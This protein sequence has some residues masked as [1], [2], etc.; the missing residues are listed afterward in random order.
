MIT[1]LYIHIPFCTAKCNYCSFTS[2]VG[3]EHLLER[4]IDALFMEMRSLAS[5]TRVAPLET[6]FLG[7]GTPSLLSSRQLARLLEGTLA[8]FPA[9]EG[10]EIS[11][12]INPGTVERA[13]LLVF[14]AAGITR[15]S[16]GVQSFVDKELREIG[17]IHT[18]SEAQVALAMAAEIGFS[19][20]SL[21]LM[22]G[23]PGQ[24]PKSWRQ[25][26]EMAISLGVGHL[27][28]YHLTLE[29]KTPFQEMVAAGTLVLPPEEELEDM[30]TITTQLMTSSGLVQYE[31]SNYARDGQYC[32]HN[33]VYWENGQYLGVGA[34]AVSF[35][36]GERRRNVARPV[37]YC[38]R[39]EAG[40]PVV[41]ERETLPL[42]ASFRESVIMGLRLNRGV[43]VQVLRQRYGIHIEDYYGKTL[44]D[45]IGG[46]LVLLQGGRLMLS[47]RGRSF[48]NVVMA[49]LV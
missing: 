44:E 24:T 6:L 1:S 28:L 22:Y 40:E 31:I 11:I 34:A 5:S 15:L 49:D 30:D 26:L 21:D 17:R 47:K 18:A 38:E 13:K 45:L 8:I 4:Y 25:S 33:I 14:K 39:L 32:R 36:G 9:Q 3:L 27:S 29:D 20:I 37:S 2:Y 35:I 46:G 16:F 23:L 10:A 41:S 12:E 19:H 43:S 48:A 7:G 42:E